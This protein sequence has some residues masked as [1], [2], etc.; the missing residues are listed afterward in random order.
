MCKFAVTHCKG[1]SNG[2]TFKAADEMQTNCAILK[3]AAPWRNNAGSLVP[4]I[5]VLLAVGSG[6][7]W[8]L[9]IHLNFIRANID[10]AKSLNPEGNSSSEGL[11]LTFCCMK[12]M[13]WAQL[14]FTVKSPNCVSKQE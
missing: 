5:N 8:L 6:G 1:K 9:G 13:D 14:L 12:D 11:D 10:F 7:K 4:F 2:V 3:R